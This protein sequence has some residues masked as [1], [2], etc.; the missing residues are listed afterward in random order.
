[1]LREQIYLINILEKKAINNEKLSPKIIFPGSNSY[2]LEP[3]D[4][5]KAPSYEEK[6]MEE[7]ASQVEKES[8]FSDTDT[9]TVIRR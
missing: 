3:E 6:Y 5:E 4:L 1:M 7:S 2:D 9:A 8:K